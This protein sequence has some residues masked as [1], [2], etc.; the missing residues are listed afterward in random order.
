T[1]DVSGEESDRLELTP[2]QQA[3]AENGLA[4]AALSEALEE[5]GIT[6][7][8]GSVSGD[9]TTLPVDGGSEI[10]SLDDIKELPLSGQPEAGQDMYDTAPAPSTLVAKSPGAQT[11]HTQSV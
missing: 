10:D 6:T 11:T 7:P 3:P 1:A 9:H 4:P 2:H 5:N 8:L